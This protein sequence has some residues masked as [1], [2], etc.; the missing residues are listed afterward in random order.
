[1]KKV[2]ALVLAAAFISSAA[3]NASAQ[4]PNL[5]LYFDTGAGFNSQTKDCPNGTPGTV[6]DAVQ[7]VLNNANAWLTSVE[8]SIAF[9]P[10]MSYAFANS[11]AT[12]AI[13]NPV[14]GHTLGW[15]LPQNAF[16]PFVVSEVNFLWNCDG[17]N[18]PNDEP[19]T[20]VANGD[21]G[22]LRMVAWPDNNVIDLVGSTSLVCP[23]AIPVQEKTWGSIKSLYNE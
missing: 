16:S 5:T 6:L 10:S 15:N 12:L 13:G 20:V 8:Y 4:V 21:T 17:C 7:V 1:M 2:L 9:P 3:F 18:P 22:F 23:G 11:S 14:S 19:V